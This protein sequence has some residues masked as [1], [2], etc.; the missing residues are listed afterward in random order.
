M[1]PSV[2]S[3]VDVLIVGAGPAGLAL[4]NWFRSS[5]ISV[6]LLDKKP[7]PTPRGQAEGLKSTTVEIFESLGIGH[8]VWAEAWRLEEIA[9]WGPDSTGGDATTSIGIKREQVIQDQV[10]ELGKTREV[11]LQQSRVEHHMLENLSAS[12]NIEMQFQKR[13][14]SLNIDESIF[15]DQDAFPLTV[16]VT[17]NTDRVGINGVAADCSNGDLGTEEIHAKYMVGCDGAHSWTRDRLGVKLEGDLTDS[18]FG[19]VDIVPKSNFPDIRKVCY[20]RA[21]TGTILLVPRSNKEVRLYVPVESGGALSNPKDLTFERIMDAVRKIIAPYTLEVG[22]CKWWSAYRV[23]QRVGDQFSIHNRVFLAGDAVHTHSPKAGQGM[24]TSIQDAFNLGWKLRLVLNGHASPSILSTYESERLPVAQDLIAFDRGYLKLFSAPS[25]SFES[26]FLRAM[27]FTT[28]LSIRYPPSPIVQLPSSSNNQEP[29]QPLG[30][31][32]LKADVVSGKR[33]PDFQVVCQADGITT[34][35]HPRLHASGAFRIIAFAGNLAQ[36]A[37]L[38]QLQ[39][40]GSWLSDC[41]EGLGR[42]TAGGAQARVEVLVVHCAARE[43]VELM[44]LHEVFR[45]WSDDEGWDYWRVYADENSAHEGHGRVYDK[46]E[47]DREKGCVVVVRP[48]NY[49][50]AVIGMEDFGSMK[51]YFSKVESGSCM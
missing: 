30:P 24:N 4:A 45:P 17:T 10:P 41:E 38:A 47:L 29:A 40:L 37:L 49:I 48:D 42:L 1:A 39:H 35:I 27:K 16:T 14:T 33:L 43:Q 20:L 36:P 12:P 23:G 31:S 5:N 2:S 32:L 44:E 21:S 26:E 51:R 3:H 11:M 46:L 28:G 9:I 8:Q 13:P 15:D 25:A 6:R 19:V 34:R 50:S 18:V 22:S 7:G